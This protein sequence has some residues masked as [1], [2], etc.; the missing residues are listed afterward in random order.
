MNRLKHQL[1]DVQKIPLA[2]Y[3]IENITLPDMRR[4]LMELHRQLLV[5]S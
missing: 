4:Q 3:L 2:D 5:A 1:T